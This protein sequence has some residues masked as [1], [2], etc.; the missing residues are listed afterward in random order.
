MLPFDK[1][2]FLWAA[3]LFVVEVLIALFVRDAIIRPYVGDFL[4]VILLYCSIRT[5]L[6]APVLKVALGVLLFAYLLEVLQYFRLVD[7]LGLTDN[8]LAK[9]VIGYGFAWLDMVAYTLGILMVVAVE[10][11]GKFKGMS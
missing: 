2:Y 3:V 10:R 9:T 11:K 7:R 1:K 6:K 4:V 5:F 8:L